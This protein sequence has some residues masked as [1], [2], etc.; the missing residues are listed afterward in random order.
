MEKALKKMKANLGRILLRF[1][2]TFGWKKPP[3]PQMLP[4]VEQAQEIT[5]KKEANGKETNGKEKSSAKSSKKV[6]RQE[7]SCSK[8]DE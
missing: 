7:G 8:E 6:S 3:T 4:L 2:L 5:N 1:S